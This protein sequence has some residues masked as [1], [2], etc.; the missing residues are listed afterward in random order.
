VING[1]YHESAAEEGN[2]CYTPR[3][4]W[5]KNGPTG[6]RNLVQGSPSLSPQTARHC[7]A[8]ASFRA[9]CIDNQFCCRQYSEGLYRGHPPPPRWGGPPLGGAPPG[10]VKI[11]PGDFS[12]GRPD[13]ARD[14]PAFLNQELSFGDD[15]YLC[16]EFPGPWL[17]G[18]P[19]RQRRDRGASACRAG[20]E[21]PTNGRPTTSPAT[22]W[23][24]IERPP[25]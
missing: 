13:V 12:R 3:V 2:A 24:P 10:R 7:A 6:Y 4:C 1:S 21:L 25:N 14:A 20:L 16:Y 5:P 9:A 19:D 15:F 17:P 23:R 11:S 8:G 22:T 18:R